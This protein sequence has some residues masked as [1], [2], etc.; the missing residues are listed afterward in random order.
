ML[1]DLDGFRRPCAGGS[2][3]FLLPAGMGECRCVLRY[4]RL[5]VPVT[6]FLG[7]VCFH[8]RFLRSLAPALLGAFLGL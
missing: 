6:S 1:T 8:L 7:R 2:Q 5:R 3:Q 4:L